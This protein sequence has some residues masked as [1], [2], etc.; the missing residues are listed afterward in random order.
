MNILEYSIER[1][2]GIL[3]NLF[4]GKKC[5]ITPEEKRQM[6]SD[7]GIDKYE[8]KKAL[9]MCNIKLS[10]RIRNRINEK[11]NEL[12]TNKNGKLEKSEVRSGTGEDY[13]GGLG[14]LIAKVLPVLM[15][16][17][18]QVIDLTKKV[19]DGMS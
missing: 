16:N 15:E 8:L 3:G 12:D 11:F 7:G 14:G 10:A 5:K 19:L 4:T 2:R 18:P 13:F 6:E 17:L 1:D 9:R